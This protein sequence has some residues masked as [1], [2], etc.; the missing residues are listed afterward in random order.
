M[1]NK[2]NDKEIYCSFC[3]K[4]QDLVL[5]M[6]QGNG[7]YICDRCVDL[8]MNIL[9]QSGEIQREKIPENQSL[10]P[11][12]PDQSIAELL[13]PKEIKAILDE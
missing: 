8:C 7:A 2:N 6:I 12:D 4:P 1:A 9:E 11:K 5:R 13:K 3:G 10:A